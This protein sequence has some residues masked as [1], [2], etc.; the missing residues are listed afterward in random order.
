MSTNQ[1][2]KLDLIEDAWLNITE[3]D[4]KQAKKNNP[5]APLPG[6]QEKYGIT[7][8]RTL[9]RTSYISYAANVLLNVELLPIQSAILAEMWN[10]PFP[11]LIGS[12][13]LGKTTLLAFYAM[14]KMILTPPSKNGNPGCKVII[15]GSGFRQAKQVFEYM[16]QVWSNAPRLRSL[17]KGT[18]G[19]GIK[20]ENDRYTL[21]IGRNYAIAIP[22]GN[23]EKV[24]GLRA[25]N[26]LA[27]EFNSIDP[28]IFETVIQGFAAVAANPIEMVK[29]RSK[30]LKA[31]ELGVD[32][33]L[34][35]RT[36]N[37]IV[38]SGTCGYDFEH[39]SSYWKRYKSIIESKG[40]FDKLM[41]IFN[42]DVN[43][44]F[45]WR[46]FS[47]IRIPF[48]RVPPG[49]LDENILMRAK[50]T[51]HSGTFG[52]EYGAVFSKDSAGFFRRSI[53]EAAVANDKHIKDSSWPSWCPVPFD[54]KLWG[55]KDKKYIIAVDPASEVDNFSIVVL[56]LWPQHSRIVYTW[57]TNK[58]NHRELIRTGFTQENDFYAFCA[59]K[60]RD[61]MKA[62]PCEHIALDAQGG[63]VAVTEALHNRNNLTSEDIPIWPIIDSEKPSPTDYEAGLHILELIQFA[64]AKWISEANHGLRHDLES[65]TLLFPRF[66]SVSLEIASA[67]DMERV[68]QFENENPG[69]KAKPFDTLED[70]V[71]EIEELK[72]ELTS[73]VLTRTG[74]GSQ[75]R[76]RWDTPEIKTPTGKKGRLRKDRYSSLLMANMV[77]RQKRV[78]QAVL[79]SVNLGGLLINAT[80]SEGAYYSQA[81]D[82]YKKLMSEFLSGV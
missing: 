32:I 15:T 52:R 8:L 16:E 25:T 19:Q 51:T 11:M 68:A 59:R 10:K 80:G 2:R 79:E 47:I 55:D 35:E 20:R 36:S 22:I 1:L 17:C 72:D 29:N 64:D 60:I 53:I 34:P 9:C 76:D 24:R 37:Q 56:E 4:I 27:D 40:D 66:D 21:T 7:E 75:S 44:A 12:R 23:G 71:F 50:A 6:D 3:E 30:A 43:P 13:G 42:G 39:F 33:V 73:I 82:D 45:N 38:I 48:S 61:L 65:K 14:L 70:I 26:V 54:A 49:F 62:F 57:T 69:L 81:P 78:Q 31:K 77:A 46:D 67:K 28:T 18:P 63:G 5:F 41:E 74:V 58:K